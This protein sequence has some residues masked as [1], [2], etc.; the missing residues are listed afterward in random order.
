M[1]NKVSPKRDVTVLT[2]RAVWAARPPT[3]PVTGRRARRQRY[4]RRQTT[5]TDDRHQRAKQYWPIRRASS[6]IQHNNLIRTNYK[7]GMCLSF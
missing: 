5:P 1:L 7:L 2:R 6:N 4:K 3:R